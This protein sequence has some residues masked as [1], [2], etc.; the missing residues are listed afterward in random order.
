MVHRMASWMSPTTRALV[1]GFG[2]QLTAMVIP[3]IAQDCRVYTIVHD[4]RSPAAGSTGKSAKSDTRPIVGRSLSLFHAGKVYDYLDSM[5]EVTVFEPA[6]GGFT[7]ISPSRRKIA[8]VALADL[9]RQLSDAEERAS[10]HCL[11]LAASPD[12]LKSRELRWTRFLLAPEFEESWDAQRQQLQLKSEL[13]EYR[14]RCT[15][16]EASTIVATYARYADWT[17]RLNYLLHPQAIA[18]GPRLQLNESLRRHGALP[19][20]VELIAVPRQEVRL[21]AKHSFAWS[22]DAKDRA[23]IREFDAMLTDRHFERVSFEA[24]QRITLEPQTVSQTSA[25]RAGSR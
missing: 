10:A 12:P 13:C 5:G 18:P 21:C 3:A 1:A 15:V 11:N 4:S 2:L 16:T 24:F 25:G 9:Q 22:L 19:V 17:A 23:M 7:L 20:E 8:W 6:R 14:V